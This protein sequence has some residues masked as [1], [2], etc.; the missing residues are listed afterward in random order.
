MKKVGATDWLSGEA[1]AQEITPAV[2]ER[3]G[4]AET[5]NECA[6]PNQVISRIV[7][8]PFRM[9]QSE[10]AGTSAARLNTR[11]VQSSE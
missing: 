1:A 4:V 6:I 10:R 3:A 8:S 7:I 11:A 2:S 5:L 9:V